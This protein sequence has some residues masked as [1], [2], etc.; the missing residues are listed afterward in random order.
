[1]DLADFAPEYANNHAAFRSFHWRAEPEHSER[2]AIVYM[3]TRDSGLVAESN[4]S[5]YERELRRFTSGSHP[6]V[7]A[8]SHSHWACG[9]VDG[10][11]I[12]VYRADGEVTKAFLAFMA[13]KCAESDYP[14]LDSADHSERV[15][16]AMEEAWGHD[17]AN[18]VEHC[19]TAGV[20]IFEARRDAVFELSDALYQRL[21]DYVNS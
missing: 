7:V 20:S 16:I 18:R 13:L 10:Y 14:I 8:E 4:A 9:Y 12:R 3:S 17:L 1:M 11:R 6:S 19:E 15:T 2:W 5:V 21:S